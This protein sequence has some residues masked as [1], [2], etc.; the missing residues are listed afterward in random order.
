[1]V[2]PIR[3]TLALGGALAASL[4]FAEPLPP[5]PDGAFTYVCIPDTQAYRSK[6]DPAEPSGW[7][8]KNK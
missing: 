3:K 7:L 6:K 4:S 2:N 5:L 8:E 1:M